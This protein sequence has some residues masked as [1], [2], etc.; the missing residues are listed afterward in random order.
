MWL[1]AEMTDS[2]FILFFLKEI[3]LDG[4]NAFFWPYHLDVIN[5]LIEYC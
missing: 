1:Y 4:S 3:K 5:R 2:V